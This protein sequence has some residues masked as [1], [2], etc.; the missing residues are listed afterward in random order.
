MPTIA[1]SY[2]YQ[3]F[4]R[5]GFVWYSIRTE[6]VLSLKKNQAKKTK[7]KHN[8]ESPAKKIYSLEKPLQ[9]LKQ[10]E[11]EKDVAVTQDMHDVQY[12]TKFDEKRM[13]LSPSW[14]DRVK[15]LCSRKRNA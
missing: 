2:G 15:L 9:L 12:D 8:R 14:I 13:M 5:R 6:I 10:K 1:A 3:H 4:Y 7:T 11:V